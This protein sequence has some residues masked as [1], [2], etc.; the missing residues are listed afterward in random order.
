MALLEPAS[1]HLTTTPDRHRQTP[2][3]R[4]AAT[5]MRTDRARRAPGT[6]A[7]A[8][9][10]DRPLRVGL[11]APPWVPVPPPA[12]GG[13]ELVVDQLARGLD[14]LGCEVVLVTTGDA[15]CPVERRPVTPN[16]LGTT[17]GL[18]AELGHVQRAYASLTD[19]DV[20]HDHTLLGPVWA[21]LSEVGVPVVTTAH[22][23]FTPDL[24]L[25]YAQVARRV[26]V[27]AISHHQRRTA[28]VVPV[29]AVIHHGIDVDRYPAGAGD[30]GYLLFL[31]RMHP[32]KGIDRAIA[33][34]RA[35]GQRLVIAAKMWEQAELTY[36]R[37][38]VEPMLGDDVVFVGQVGGAS[39]LELLGGATALVNPIRWPEPFGLVMIEA[40]ACGTPVLAFPEGAAPEIVDHGRT[41]FLCRDETDMAACVPH[42]AALDRDAC[43]LDVATRFSTAR[44]ARQHL[45]LYRHELARRGVVFGMDL[46]VAG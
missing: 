37:D 8:R 42:V 2:L 36:F 24:A 15:T 19:V 40:L 27:V 30:G 13:T 46:T 20:V 34:A 38:T 29:A 35:A 3:R 28:P 12:Y 45:A 17:A 7:G 4:P 18:L 5:T 6:P 16:A 31:G 44:M 22:G 26:A 32:D 10:V 43:R 9:A 33:V 1:D 21:N 23:P 41:G 14:A 39:K 25:L 11:I